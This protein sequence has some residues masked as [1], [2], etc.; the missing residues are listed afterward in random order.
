HGRV[1]KQVVGSGD[2]GAAARGIEIQLVSPRVV[3][4]DLAT[5]K[6][7]VAELQGAARRPTVVVNEPAALE[8]APFQLQVGDDRVGATKIVVNRG[9]VPIPASGQGR[10]VGILHFG[11]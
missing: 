5:L 11:L 7:S 8:V 6:Y 9:E 4:P 1:I 2:L 10:E 3:E